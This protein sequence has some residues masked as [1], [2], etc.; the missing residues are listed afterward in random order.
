M[1]GHR[2]R[3]LVLLADVGGP[4][5]HVGD[6][7]MLAANLRRL[8]EAAPET[9]ITVLGRAADAGAIAAALGQADGAMVSGGGNLSSSWPDLVGQRLFLL[10]ECRRLGL[11]VVVGGQ[12][13][14]PELSASEAGTLDAALTGV[15][16]LGVRE[17]P[18]LALALDLGISTERLV[19]QVDDAF[20]LESEPPE[21][22]ALVAALEAACVA[23]TFD[24]SFGAADARAEL[25][26]I[27]SQLAVF[28][29]E[30]GLDIV[31]VPHV[32][33]LGEVGS[34]D[35]APARSVHDLLRM[36]GVRSIVAPVLEP[37]AAAWMAR[38][39]K[40][41]VSSR[42]HPV[43][44]ASGAATPCLCIARD[45]YTRIKL[46]GAMAHVG[47]DGCVL[48][49]AS[50]RAGELTDALRRV[51]GERDVIAATMTAARPGIEAREDQRW[52][53]VLEGLGFAPGQPR[54]PAFLGWPPEKLALATLRAVSIRFRR[55]HDDAPPPGPSPAADDSAAGETAAP[56]GTSHAP[57][58]AMISDEQWDAFSRDG[59]MHL[60]PVLT[61]AEVQALTERADELAMGTVRNDHVKMQLDTG[62]AY[63][64]LPEAVDAFEQGT[65]LY[66]KIQGLEM[67]DRFVSLVRHPLFLEVCARMYGPHAAVSIFRAMVMNKPAGQGTALPWHQD[68]GDTW[69]LDRD[70]LV[71]IW[72]ALD[73][74]T[75]ANGCMDAVRGSHRL[76]LLTD[77]GSNISDEHAALHCPPERVV[78]LEVESG[79]AILLHNWLI[80]RSG[81]NPSS[82]PRRAVTICYMD[83]RTL[84]VLTG[85]HFP[86][87]S[88]ALRGHPY[89]FVRE[90]QEDRTALRT[91]FASAEEYAHSLEQEVAR[92]RAQREELEGQARNLEGE[93][94]RLEELLSRAPMS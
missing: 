9:Q 47:V 60:G 68:G 13:I 57:S 54:A 5:F 61:L 26:S 27:A 33:P 16:L 19:Y 76:G 79:H 85:D 87:I 34:E 10:E 4:S 45:A 86:M 24:G 84:S 50:A 62:G 67:D 41:V 58:P 48:P 46:E 38:R 7:A 80:H 90:M 37:R 52:Q 30:S 31:L 73:P 17:L 36:Q 92:L 8:H 15:E 59:F 20:T 55:Q 78:P 32:G 81:V 43:V 22:A 44:F 6:E 89:H 91:T 82:Q 35:G 75:R 28:A 53:G 69:A 23:I 66:R 71:T 94:A 70:P 49:V 39:A 2:P 42:Y 21:D 93:R 18:S 65:R 14:G 88:G 3:S 51:W 72:V 83:G 40:L 12:T 74:A 25:C 29:D 1:A 56:T 77:A 64:A 63:E 11:P